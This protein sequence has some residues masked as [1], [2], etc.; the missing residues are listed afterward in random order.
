MEKFA[1]KIVP[2]GISLCLA[3]IGSAAKLTNHFVPSV[4]C[5]TKLFHQLCW[6]SIGILLP[7][8]VQL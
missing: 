3:H 2:A 5:G 1:Y 6:Y 8:V 4:H 7:V